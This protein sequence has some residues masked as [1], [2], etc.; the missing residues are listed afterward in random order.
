[1]INRQQGSLPRCLAVA[2]GATAGA[3]AL[4]A[5]LLPTA[6]APGAETFDGA[7]VRLCAAGAVPV[8]GWLWLG[9]VLT[10]LGAVRG[11]ARSRAGVPAPLRRVV[12]AAC[13]VALTCGLLLPGPVGATPGRPHVDR[14]TSPP[15][16]IAGLPLPD[17]ATAPPDRTGRPAHPGRVVVVAPGDTLWTIAARERARNATDAE[18]DAAWRRLYALN[19]AEIGPDPDLIRPAQRL[20]VLP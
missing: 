14:S 7:L 6:T 8:A 3:G 4:V 18:I 20:E 19:R 1:M 10:A 13:G 11:Q 15:A 12:L 2:T 9:V 17:R 16:P 5:W